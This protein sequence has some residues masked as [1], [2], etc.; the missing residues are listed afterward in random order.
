M[1]NSKN[2][3]YITAYLN[4][5]KVGKTSLKIFP[6]FPIPTLEE[7]ITVCFLEGIIND[8]YKIKLKK[9]INL[10]KEDRIFEY[11]KY[12]RF[13]IKFQNDVNNLE[14]TMYINQFNILFLIYYY[15]YKI[16]ENIYLINKYHYAHAAFSKIKREINITL[17]LIKKCN[18]IV[19]EI[20]K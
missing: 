8:K 11:I 1:K 13:E 7:N 19:D 9:T 15:Y 20:S 6:L 3:V 12:K 17:D 5:L 4:Q 18:I 14:F 2:G 16:K 10:I